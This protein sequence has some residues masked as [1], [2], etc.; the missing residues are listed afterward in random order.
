MI[1]FLNVFWVKMKLKTAGK[2]GVVE[3]VDAEEAEDNQIS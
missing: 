1:I 2:A 3:E